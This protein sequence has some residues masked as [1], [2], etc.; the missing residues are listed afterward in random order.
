MCRVL[1]VEDDLLIAALLSEYLDGL[2]FDVVGP[3]ASLAQTQELFDASI[4][5]VVLD[6]RLGPVPTEIFADHLA[7]VDI[8]FAFLT[9]DC[10][11]RIPERHA[12]RPIQTKPF[13]YGQIHALM[14]EILPASSR[15]EFFLRA[16]A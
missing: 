11:V 2:G 13:T 1:I 4:E 8:P 5:A 6:T 3:A 14:T 16:T 9:A 7:A 12:G 15:P 10:P